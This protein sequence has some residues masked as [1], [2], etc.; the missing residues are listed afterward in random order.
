MISTLL[1]ETL[2]PG[3]VEVVSSEPPEIEGPLIRI[4]QLGDGGS[5]NTLNCSQK[6]L[7]VA[8]V[9]RTCTLEDVANS[10]WMARSSFG[11]TSPYAPDIILVNE[12]A[13]QDFVNALISTCLK[14]HDVYPS[15]SNGHFSISRNIKNSLQQASTCISSGAWGQIIEIT[16]RYS[17]PS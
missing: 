11:G 8:I 14:N 15:K 2:D 12:F 17:F 4:D 6:A 1:N 5:L 10:I 16:K 13:K 3:V 7:T 9:D